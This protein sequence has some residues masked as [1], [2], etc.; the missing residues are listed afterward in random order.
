MRMNRM[1]L[2]CLILTMGLSACHIREREQALAEKEKSIM[3]R[4]R[5][6]ILREQELTLRE[7]ELDQM[8]MALDSTRQQID[9]TNI[10]DESIVG[11]WTVKMLC[12]ETSCEGSA[13]GDT[14]T[15]QWEIKYGEDRLVIAKAYSGR[16]LIRI[17]NG[18]LRTGGLKLIDENNIRVEL[19]RSGKNKM[20][21]IREI[22]P[23]GCKIVY[24]LTADKTS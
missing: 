5:N 18:Y 14:R 4:E 21:G 6:L 22:T 24:A 8:E 3:A 20:E 13:I 1:I 19:K 23:P 9:S 2:L 17:Y 11:K 15:E 12:Q 10:Y 7:Y 16:K